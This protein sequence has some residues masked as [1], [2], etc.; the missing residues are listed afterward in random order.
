MSDGMKDLD[1]INTPEHISRNSNPFQTAAWIDSWLETWGDDDRLK[2]IDLGGAGKACE[3]IVLA[4]KMI[5]GIIPSQ[6]LFLPGTAYGPALSPRSEYNSLSHLQRMAGSIDYLSKELGKLD[7]TQ[8]YIPDVVLG[9]KDEAQ[10]HCL[11]K[12]S[13]KSMRRESSDMAY[14]VGGISCEEFKQRISKST[15]NQYFKGRQRLAKRGT[16]DFREY[17]V[18]EFPVFCKLLNEFHITRWGRPCYSNDSQS[19]LEGFLGGFS[20][21]QGIVHL[22]ALML[23]G[24]IISL[25]FD[26]E[27]NGRRY[28]LQSGFCE[29]KRGNIALGSIHLGYSIERALS[30]SLTYD[31][32]AG[33]GRSTNYKANISNK[34]INLGSFFLEPR[35][36]NRIHSTYQLAKNKLKPRP[37]SAK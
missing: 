13:S 16:I 11:G 33:T 6:V 28:N 14:S 27:L 25:I 15:R 8:V 22:Q 35:W 23:E 3:K 19:F 30:Q 20:D 21:E 24:D 4:K 32:L 29:K 18:K 17:G 34:T 10:I 2:I 31:F 9:G 37:P 7:W 1:G 26:I 5:K 12:C 36:L